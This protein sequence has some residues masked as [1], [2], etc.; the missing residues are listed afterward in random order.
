M[1]SFS[2][3][4]SESLNLLNLTQGNATCYG[5]PTDVIRSSYH[6]EGQYFSKFVSENMPYIDGFVYASRFT[7]E[8]C[9][10]LYYNRAISK[11]SASIPVQLNKDIV[12]FAMLSKNIEVE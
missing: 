4:V 10:A 5:V 11:L 2:S 1:V 9:L 12:K 3:K 6:S 8:D 7:E